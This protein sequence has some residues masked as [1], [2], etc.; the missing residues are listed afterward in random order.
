MS[1]APSLSSL[2]ALS[3]AA[4]FVVPSSVALGQAPN[5]GDL[6]LLDPTVQGPS[7]SSGALVKYDPSTG[8]GAMVVD[9]FTT[10]Q[11][12]QSLAYDRTRGGVV[13]VGSIVDVFQ[14]IHLWLCDDGGSLTDLGL[15]SQ[16]FHCIT[17]APDGKIYGRATGGGFVNG[18]VW[19][20]LGDGL[21]HEL[22]DESGA[23]PFTFEPGGFVD[24]R[25]LAFHEATRSLVMVSGSGSPA[26]GGGISTG[27]VVKRV[28]L[29][30]DGTRAVGP[31]DCA[32]FEV[33]S[34]GESPV[35]ISELPDGDLLVVVDTNSNATE[36][37]AL[38][39][40]PQTLAISVFAS[41]GG[42][43]GAAATNGGTWS[44]ALGKCALLDTFADDLRLYADGDSGPGTLLGVTLPTGASGGSGETATL[45]EIDAPACTG[46]F[47]AYDT[48][49]A[50]SGGYE[51][52]L[53]G[54]G[55]PE[56]GATVFVHVSGARGG[57]QAAI[58]AGFSSSALPFKGGL[59]LVA[60]VLLTVPF[61]TSGTPG[62]AGVGEQLIPF[63]LPVSG[64]S[65][66]S[67]Y[68]QG[69]VADPAAT[70][71]VALT[72]GLSMTIG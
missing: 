12:T 2:R 47:E 21:L 4:A 40:H 22:L 11:Q 59:L 45:V 68:M 33:S 28:T 9:T 18:R 49:L 55:C 61:T 3:I 69:A 48:G 71:G 58:F 6:W 44:S 27:I 34:S 25:L 23:A 57:S 17:P 10:P 51:P 1:F 20:T 54:T 62:E 32:E 66:V 38:R 15:V 7:S 24:Y 39:I 29:S 63:P 16:P 41:N 42:Y 46:T 52:V 13:F 35:G 37:R 65:G 50:G 30:A 5:V 72:A 43:T 14:P 67:L 64:V 36:P 26:C 19:Y 31:I 8:T 70:W 53:A 56:P 60:P